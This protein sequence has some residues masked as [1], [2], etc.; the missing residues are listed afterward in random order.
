M[1]ELRDY[2]SELAQ[3]GCKILQDVGIVYFNCEVRVGKTLMALEAAR[4]YG[5]KSVLFLTKKKAIS[6]ILGDYQKM[7]DEGMMTIFS[8]ADLYL[9]PPEPAAEKYHKDLKPGYALT[10]INNESI[11]KVE[12]DFDLLVVDEVH[13]ISGYPKPSKMAKDLRERF[14]HLPMI[15][16]SGTPSP[17]SFSQLYHQFWISNRSPFVEPNFYK[18]AGSVGKPNYV[19]VVQRT[20]PHGTV[21]DYSNGIEEKILPAIEPY[22]IRYTQ[23]QAGFVCQIT[24]HIC[25][26]EMPL[27]L[28]RVARQIMKDGVVEGRSG[29]LSAD[30]P[31][32]KLQKVHQ[33]HSGTCILDE[34]DE[35]KRHPLLLSDAKAQYIAERWP[36]EKLVIFYQF[37]NEL[38]LLQKVLG[39]RITTDLAE[40][41]STDKSC[42]FQVVSGREGIDL[43]L[44]EVIVFYNTSFSAVSYFQ[45]RDR[46]TTSTR[47]SSDIYWLFSQFDGEWGIEKKI[48]DVVMTKRS[49]TARHFAKDF[50]R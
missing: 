14:S 11:H 32:A 13:R 38:L 24:E 10:V 42:A 28:A 2:Q 1:F 15:L 48:Y 36:N 23:E 12:G 31:A 46:L 20:F 40:F 5:A 49:Y 37:K 3:E 18:W 45:A 25:P 22:M 44:G 41:Q 39:D 4:I 27:T 35:G 8:D 43:S 47:R 7:L 30:S 9:D 29:T 21:N 34:D 19:N 16:M 33:L 17:E 6:S 50:L 26:V